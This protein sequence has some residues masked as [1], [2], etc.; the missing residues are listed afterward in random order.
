MGPDREAPETPS[1]GDNRAMPQLLVGPIEALAPSLRQQIMSYPPPGSD[2]PSAQPDAHV[3]QVVLVEGDEVLS[4]AEITSGI[5]EHDAARLV[6]RGLSDVWT[7]PAFRG[8]GHG[9]RVVEAATS[10]IRASEADLGML[11]CHPDLHR[12]YAAAGWRATPEMVVHFD[13]PDRPSLYSGESVMCLFVSEQ[14]IVAAPAMSSGSVY[15][16]RR[17]W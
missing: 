15:L 17:L 12:F 4:Y 16:G 13:P 10:F 14:G 11:F 8:R 7:Y 1:L 9:S 6:V 3:A 2:L 5:A